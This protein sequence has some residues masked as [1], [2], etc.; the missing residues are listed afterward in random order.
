VYVDTGF[1][2][3][4]DIVKAVAM[5]ARAV[6]FANSILLAWGAGREDGVR[7]FVELLGAEMRRTMSALGCPD[8]ASLVDVKLQRVIT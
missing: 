3:G 1:K 7:R 8:C 4:N 6:G 5:G 2:T